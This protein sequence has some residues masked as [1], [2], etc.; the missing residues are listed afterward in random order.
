MLEPL[1]AAPSL[2]PVD[3]LWAASADELLRRARRHRPDVMVLALPAPDVDH[4]PHARGAQEGRRHGAAA[5]GRRR[6]RARPGRPRRSRGLAVGRRAPDRGADASCSA[7]PRASPKGAPASSSSR[8]S[9]RSSTS[10]ASCSSAKATTSSRV[11]SGDDALTVVDDDVDLVILDIVLADA[12][13]IE[14]CRELKSR[15]ATA[16]TSRC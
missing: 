15:E 14:I 3:I 13:G 12:D 5:G 16:R 7:A 6:R 8:T 11:T 4:R 10:R 9:S 2:Q 1:L